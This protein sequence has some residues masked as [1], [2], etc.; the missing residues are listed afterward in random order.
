MK[1]LWDS[2]LITSRL[3]IH[4]NE[5]LCIFWRKKW[6][7]N[8]SEN[9]CH[10][11]PMRQTSFLCVHLFPA[12]PCPPNSHY[13]ECT[14]PC[15]PTCADLFPVFCPLPPN[16]CV[17]GCQCN[18]GF[19]LSDGKCVPLS[20]CGCVDSNGE[21]HDVSKVARIAYWFYYCSKVFFL[22]KLI[23]FFSE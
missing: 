14:A 19:V 2:S 17:E 18:G 23:V 1:H 3:C 15:P 9:H 11:N 21:Y 5:N 6:P 22:K 12:L 16:S 4:I 10:S 7:L 13:S 20:S 8:I